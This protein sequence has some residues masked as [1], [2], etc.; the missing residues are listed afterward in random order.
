MEAPSCIGQGHEV[1]PE[2]G[3][4]APRYLYSKGP[5]GNGQGHEVIP[6]LRKETTRSYIIMVLALSGKAINLY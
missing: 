4:E 6:E 5:S 1:I 3:K 2:L